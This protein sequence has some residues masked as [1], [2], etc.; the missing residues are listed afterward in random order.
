MERHRLLSFSSRRASARTR[1]DGLRFLVANRTCRATTATI[2][3]TILVASDH[4]YAQ[5]DP[6]PAHPNWQQYVLGP[7]NQDV[8]PV[9]IVSVSG[10]VTNPQGLLD[11]NS[12]SGTTLTTSA[13]A[14]PASIL[15]D[16]GQDTNG[17]PWFN[18]TSAQ[19]SPTLVAAYSE[20]LQYIQANPTQGD[21]SPPSS[22]AGDPSRWDAYA[23]ASAGTI[24]NP[25]I[26][27]GERFQTVTLTT[28]GT[29]TLQ[30]VGIQ[31]AGYRATPDDYAGYFVCSSDQLNQIWYTGAYTVQLDQLPAN[32]VPL[33]WHGTSTGLIAAGGPI[34]LLKAGTN[35]TDYQLTFTTQI[36]NNQSGWIVRA[37]DFNDGY[38]FILAADNDTVGTPN[39]LQVLVLSSG[40]Y[41]S[42]ENPVLPFD[43]KPNTWHTVQTTVSGTT[44]TVSVDGTQIAQVD[45][46]KAGVPIFASGGV[47]FREYASN[48]DFESAEFQSLSLVTSSGQMVFQNSLET[49]NAVNYFNLEQG[50]NVLPFV[51]DGAKRDRVV[52]GGDL[53]VEGPNIFYSTG[54]NDYIKDS[55]LLLGSY[56]LADGEAGSNIAPTSPIGTFPE[57]VSSYS[58]P[59][60]MYFVI[61]LAKYYLFTGDN[62]FVAQEWPVVERELLYLQGLTNSQGMFVSDSSDGL[63]WHYYDG[64]LTGMVTAYNALYFEVLTDAALLAKAANHGNLASGYQ[65]EAAAVETGINSNLF[66]SATGVYDLSSDLRGTIAQDGNSLAV[67]DDIAPAAKSSE[68]LTTLISQLNTPYGPLSFSTN[69]NFAQYVSGFASN[70]EVQALF[71]IGDTGDALNL[72]NTVWGEMIQASPDYSGAD[73]EVIDLNGLPGF[74]AFT[75]LAH[76]WASGATSALSGYVLGVRP[77]TPGFQT[78]IVQPQPGDLQ[79]AEG[80][81]PT[82][83]GPIIVKWGQVSGRLIMEVDAPPG[84]SGTLAIPK[85]KAPGTVMLNGKPVWPSSA[86]A[87]G[88]NAYSATSD[89]NFIY[90]NNVPAGQYRIECEP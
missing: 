22:G 10:N 30:A 26:Q 90:L 82:P 45:V 87:K 49:A 31:F 23:V 43:L 16:Y 42:I 9:K 12:S 62:V 48:S 17:I 86:V 78:W 65:K 71:H 35:L 24:V 38:V 74:G 59:Y 7:K 81:T 18:L 34:G 4:I 83:Y 73:W 58:A 64:P 89:A 2:G 77:V 47:G 75:S 33:P 76:G 13:G 44:L 1:F 6:W 39:S 57:N 69:T 55:L 8:Y 36:L 84:T 27:G 20:G 63:D 14:T 61:N 79:W 19:G 32:I 15:L 37:Q 41:T 56:Q 3:L 72:I 66:N 85:S 67:L 88:K 29:V 40:N 11:P 50:T 46:S 80:Q 52:W 60:S 21:Q 70:M 25:Y 68:I 53:S 5:P 54:A 51:L 28:P